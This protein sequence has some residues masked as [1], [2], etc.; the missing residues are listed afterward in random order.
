[1]K[2]NTLFSVLAF[3]CVSLVQASCQIPMPEGKDEIFERQLSLVDV[4]NALEVDA[5]GAYEFFRV[6][7][8][9]RSR[10]KVTL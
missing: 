8:H 7:V 2:K 10:A 3:L 9:N 4:N 5:W 6:E 1:M